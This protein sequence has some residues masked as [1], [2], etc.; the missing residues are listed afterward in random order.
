[1][2]ELSG[3]LGERAAERGGAEALVEAATGLRLTWGQVLAEAR[4]REEA[5]RR[6]GIEPRQRVGLLVPRSASYLVWV[7]ALWRVG[8]VVVPLDPTSPEAELQG[9]ARH[10]DLAWL[11]ADLEAAPQAEA[12]DAGLLDARDG[13]ARRPARALPEP[14]PPEDALI[15]YTSGST[16]TPKG[17]CHTRGSL[18]ASAHA[19][20]R[21]YW[22]ERPPRI[23]GVLPLDHSHGLFVHGLSLLASGGTLVLAPP[24]DLFSAAATWDLA[25][26]ERVDFFSAVP[27]LFRLLLYAAEGPA[28]EGMQVYS[29]SAPLPD[30]LVEAFRERFGLTLANNFGMTETAGWCLLSGPEAPAGSIGRPHAVR[31]RVTRKGEMVLSGDQVFRAYWRQ[32]GGPRGSWFRTGDAVEVDEAGWVY[33]RG[34]LKRLLQCG[35]MSVQPEDLEAAFRSL[36]GV[37]DCAVVGVEDPVYGEQPRAFVVLKEGAE[38]TPADL[39]REARRLL[40]SYRCPRWIEVVDRIP[41]T[42]RGK[43]DLRALAAR[44]LSRL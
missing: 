2:R 26:Q 13:A 17:V 28:P 15:L 44:P 27:P 14:S 21:R 22:S 4:R 41:T 8:A 5:L 31:L 34:R 12:L 29:A 3:L 7:H 19:L 16:G 43:P 32:G 33:Y 10:A 23:L 6:A 18:A 20:A 42:P 39:D 38:L 35:G 30:D 40:A 11:V 37:A 25:R 1:M 24:L 9:L 36:P